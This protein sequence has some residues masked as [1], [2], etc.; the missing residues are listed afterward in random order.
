VKDNRYVIISTISVSYIP[1]I[2]TS[3]PSVSYTVAWSSTTRRIHCSSMPVVFALLYLT[4]NVFG[5]LCTCNV[6]LIQIGK[7][8]TRPSFKV[9][10]SGSNR[11]VPEQ[12][13]GYVVKCAEPYA[14]TSELFPDY[15]LVLSC[16]RW[17]CFDQQE[18]S[19]SPPFSV[20]KNIA[21]L[22]GIGAR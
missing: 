18:A 3:S 16:W 7:Y 22:S 6:I 17:I 4:I 8:R 1:S 14:C 12:K 19:R 2:G 5:I 21:L 9:K 20:K 10:I 15:I 13:V 11:S